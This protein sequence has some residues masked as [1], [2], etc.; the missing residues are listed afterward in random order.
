M[1]DLQFE[2]KVRQ[3]VARVNKDLS[4]LEGDNGARFIRFEDDVSQ[5]TGKAKKDLI[6]KMEVSVSQANEGIKSMKGKA[7]QTVVTLT[8]N[9]K[10]K[11]ERGLSQYDAKAQEVAE[12]FPGGFGKKVARYPWVMITIALVFGFLLGSLLK[13]GST[14][15]SRSQI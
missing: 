6:T 4:T 7:R 9:V 11:V 10:E 8:G 15:L 14:S 12:Q 2:K 3:D 13:S 1:S 5:A